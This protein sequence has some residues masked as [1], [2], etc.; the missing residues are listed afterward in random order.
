MYYMML[1]FPGGNMV[2]PRM[3]LLWLERKGNKDCT[4]ASIATHICLCEVRIPCEYII[5][6][7]SGLFSA[8]SH[9]C[10]SN[11][12]TWIWYCTAAAIS[13]IGCR[14]NQCQHRVLVLVV[15]S[16]ARYVNYLGHELLTHCLPCASYC[17]MWRTGRGGQ[18]TASFKSR[19]LCVTRPFRR[20]YTFDPVSTSSPNSMPPWI[21]VM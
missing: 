3:Y 12:F 4:L 17:I 15:L 19:G 21:R 6:S 13:V 14:I 18:Y 16:V 5:T 1:E 7:F 20:L 9:L 11:S 2:F 8:G 10:N